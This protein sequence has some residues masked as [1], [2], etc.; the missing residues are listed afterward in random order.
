MEDKKWLEKEERLLVGSRASLTIANPLSVSLSTPV[1]K[2]NV[3]LEATLSKAS[4][5]NFSPLVHSRRPASLKLNV[6]LITVPESGSTSIFYKMKLPVLL[7]DPMGPEEAV[8]P[9]VGVNIYGLWRKEM[10]H[11]S[12]FQFYRFC[13]MSL[14]L[15]FEG[16]HEFFCCFF[17]S[18]E[19]ETENGKGFKEVHRFSSVSFFFHAIPPPLSVSLSLPVIYL[20]TAPPEKPPRLTAQ[21][22]I[23]IYTVIFFLWKR[24]ISF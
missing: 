9:V 24:P 8:G 10:K 23:S 15:Y 2:F 13:L 1:S 18:P 3:A 14:S 21:V 20:S 17:Q 4:L 5:H 12:C 19:A 7:Q 6:P 22:I 16:P 11:S